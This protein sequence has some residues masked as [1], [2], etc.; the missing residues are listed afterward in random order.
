MNEDCVYI[1]RVLIS[2]GGTGGHVYPALAIADAIKAKHPEANIRF[3]GAMGRMEMEKVPQYGY[4]I[5]GITISGIN[6][7]NIFKNWSLPFKLFK[8]FSK[9][10]KI[11]KEFKPQ[12]VIGVG[13]YASGPLLRIAAKRHIPTL[14][15]EQNSFPGITNK[16]L[17][18]DVNTICVAYPGLEKY[19]PAEKIVLTGNP[20][21]KFNASVPQH[22]RGE[23]FR[24]FDLEP[25]GGQV[26]LILGGSLGAKTINESVAKHLKELNERK[27]QLIWQTGKVHYENVLGSLGGQ[28]GIF[29]F[30]DRMDY[31]YTVAD[32]VISRA[33]AIS[34]SELAMV[35]KP[36]ILVPSPNVAEDHQAKNAVALANSNAA[37]MVRDSEAMDK[38]IPETIALLENK[39]R[40]KELSKN[41]AAFAKPDAAK[42]IVEEVEKIALKN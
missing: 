30:I 42:Q 37:I 40:Q 8:S 6:R 31:A 5:D 39:E 13:G 36:V 24:Y 1:K 11:L 17:A 35:G 4:A 9:V 38:L 10:R 23:A 7:K 25:G 27:I 19:F 26:L 22:E 2:G 14:I 32:V 34:I 20:I 41:I 15:Q 16:I 12:A 28:P 18:K 33:G 29:S 3:V 21:R